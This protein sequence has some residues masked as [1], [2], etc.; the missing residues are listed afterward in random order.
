MFYLLFV[1][2]IAIVIFILVIK[3]TDLSKKFQVM[4]TYIAGLTTIEDVQDIVRAE[5]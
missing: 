4:E 2:V 1:L 3:L 5:Q